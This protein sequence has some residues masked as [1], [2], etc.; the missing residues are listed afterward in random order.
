M[1]EMFDKCMYLKFNKRQEDII[2]HRHR[3]T[4]G[5]VVLLLLNRRKGG[6]SWIATSSTKRA[7]SGVNT[8]KDGGRH[9]RYRVN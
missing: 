4:V 8:E 7:S 6:V 1:K 2:E 9:F 5:Q 3:F